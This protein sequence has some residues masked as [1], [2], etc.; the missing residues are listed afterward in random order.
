MNLNQILFIYFQ[1]SHFSQGAAPS[2]GEKGEL[3]LLAICSPPLE[4]LFSFLLDPPAPTNIPG[5]KKKRRDDGMRDHTTGCA[6]SEGYYKIDKKDKIKYLQST[7]LQS[8]EPPVDTQ[9]SRR[10][11]RQPGPPGGSDGGGCH[12]S[13]E[14]KLFAFSLQGMSI[15]A[16]VHASTRAGSERRSEQRRL[17]S[18]FACDSDLLKF[19]QL[20]VERGGEEEGWYWSGEKKKIKEIQTEVVALVFVN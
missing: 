16:Q 13:D 15:P 11:A 10:A 1:V 4:D 19:N 17:L 3:S 7:K 5:V 18:S 2:A 6:R 20:K 12:R 14:S 9:V 8:E